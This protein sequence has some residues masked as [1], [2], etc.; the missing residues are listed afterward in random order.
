MDAKP[1]S[2]YQGTRDEMLRFMPD[3]AATVL[4]IGCGEGNF[5]RR[6]KDRGAREV[7]GVELLEPVAQQ[8]QR[9]LDRVLIGDIADLTDQLPDDY[10]DLVICNDVLEHMVDPFTVLAMLKGKISRRG[11]VVSSIPNIRYYPTFHEILVH[12][13]WEY[14]ESGVLDRTHL[15]FFTKKSIRKMYERLGY[16]VLLHEGI[17]PMPDRPTI[18]RLANAILRGK[19]SD[20][21]WVQFVTMARPARATPAVD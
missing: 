5:G 10:F 18:Y 17:N 19:L 11:V 9:V 16:E 4:E 15:R 2:Y 7:W 12:G 8:A 20:M 1:D 14:E 3:D 21:Q 6:L 13:Q